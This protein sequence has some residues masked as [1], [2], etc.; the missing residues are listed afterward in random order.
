MISVT[1][2]AKGE[3]EA[4]L[5]SANLTMTSTISTRKRDPAVEETLDEGNQRKRKRQR[6][7]NY[8]FHLDSLL[9]YLTV[10]GIA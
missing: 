3:T 8:P 2:T 9:T 7:R 4:T 5:I 1:T 6:L 10:I